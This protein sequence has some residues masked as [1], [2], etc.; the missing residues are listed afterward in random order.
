MNR[1]ENFC[2][3]YS[4]CGSMVEEWG[5]VLQRGSPWDAVLRATLFTLALCTLVFFLSSF[6]SPEAPNHTAITP[7][8]DL[9]SYSFVILLLKFLVCF[10]L[11]PLYTF[12][13]ENM[14]NTNLWKPSPL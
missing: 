5:L 9:K 3:S 1:A 6:L 2:L 11:F 13:L 7:S 10:L 12:S 14:I 4:S 8:S